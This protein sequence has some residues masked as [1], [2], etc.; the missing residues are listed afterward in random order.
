MTSAYLTAVPRS[1]EQAMYDTLV[2]RLTV[3]ECAL[4]NMK[5]DDP[6]RGECARVIRAIEVE[7][8]GLNDLL[9]T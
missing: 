9:A 8:D 7:I 6:R 3:E 1:R 5:L 4:R 2:N